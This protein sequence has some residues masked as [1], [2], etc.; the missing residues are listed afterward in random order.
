MGHFLMLL[1]EKAFKEEINIDIK[2][3]AYLSESRK[4]MH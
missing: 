4:G 1:R 2:D 3:M